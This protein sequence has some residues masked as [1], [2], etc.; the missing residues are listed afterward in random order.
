MRKARMGS[1][2]ARPAN[3]PYARCTVAAGCLR[4][5]VGFGLP[6][7]RRIEAN[8]EPF[9]VDHGRV[10]RTGLDGR[11]ATRRAQPA[12]SARPRSFSGAL[13]PQSGDN[14]RSTAAVA[15]A[16]GRIPFRRRLAHP[17]RLLLGGRRDDRECGGW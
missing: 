17:R 13:L 4:W 10:A 2:G 16:C 9:G 3:D 5:H 11:Q 6:G 12:W 15:M 7:G 1:D 14:R 8:G